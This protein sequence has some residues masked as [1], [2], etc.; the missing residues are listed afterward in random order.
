MKKT[1]TVTQIQR[2]KVSS[3]FY[4]QFK[5]RLAIMLCGLLFVVKLEMK[6]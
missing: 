4:M 3:I 6:L 5:C 1:V 2:I